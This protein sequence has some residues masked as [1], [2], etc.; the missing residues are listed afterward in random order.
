[1]KIFVKNICAWGSVWSACL[2][3]RAWF[4]CGAVLACLCQVFRAPPGSGRGVALGGCPLAA[5]AWCFAG[6]AFTIGLSCGGAVCCGV[7]CSGGFGVGHLGL[8]G[9]SSWG[10]LGG[11]GMGGRGR[12]RAWARP[13]ASGGWTVR[14]C[15][16][17]MTPT[18]RHPPFL[19]SFFISSFEFVHYQRNVNAIDSGN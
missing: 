4:V 14:F 18:Q 2:W 7:P 10:V 1:M 5:C 19:T 9:G 17:W 6:S 3:L 16:R 15:M 12:C 11:F 8:H 13:G